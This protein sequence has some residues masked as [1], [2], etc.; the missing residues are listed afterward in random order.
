MT[1]I[2]AEEFKIKKES[3]TAPTIGY[4][5]WYESD[6]G[7]VIKKYDSGRILSELYLFISSSYLGSYMSIITE[8]LPKK[9]KK[10][11]SRADIIAEIDAL[12]GVWA[13]RDD[14]DWMDTFR[15]DVGRAWGA[16]IAALYDEEDLST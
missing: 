10:A 4:S 9:E 1:T 2:T 11:K 12:Y 16:R 5:I 7:P 6:E 3:T 15:E 8:E 14:L 13:D